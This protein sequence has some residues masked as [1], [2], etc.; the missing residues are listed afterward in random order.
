MKL[1]IAH[2]LGNRDASLDKDALMRN[3]VAEVDE[4]GQ[5]VRARKRPAIDS[6]FT[7]SSGAGQGLF[8]WNIPGP[9][10]P[11]TYLVAITNNTVNTAPANVVKSLAF[12]VQPT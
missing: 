8:V 4:Q 9:L 1:P 10:A 2:T 7:A 5:V 11:V 12:T 6:A 3:A